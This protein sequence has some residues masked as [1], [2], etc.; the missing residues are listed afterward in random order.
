MFYATFLNLFYI[1]QALDVFTL[2]ICIY[3][4][5]HGSCHAGDFGMARNLR[6]LDGQPIAF[7]ES[8]QV[9]A[10][11]SL[12]WAPEL[13][14]WHSRGPCEESSAKVTFVESMCSA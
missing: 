13:I 5:D 12:A 9:L 1:Y 10:G 8:A 14:Q 2:Y 11:N 7:V 6:A 3:S 4:I